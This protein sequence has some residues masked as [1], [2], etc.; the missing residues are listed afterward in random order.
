MV[1]RRG[2]G[3]WVAVEGFETMAGRMKKQQQVRDLGGVCWRGK[4]GSLGV[5]ASG[6]CG[7]RA[8]T[9]P[10]MGSQVINC[11][12]AVRPDRHAGEQQNE[13]KTARR[14]AAVR[15]CGLGGSD[16]GRVG[17]HSHAPGGSLRTPASWPPIKR[18]LQPSLAKFR[19]GQSRLHGRCGGWP[20]WIA[21]I[22]WGWGAGC[23]L[24]R[25]IRPWPSRCAGP[26]HPAGVI[27]REAPSSKLC[28]LELVERFVLRSAAA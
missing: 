12:T 26:F 1:V 27:R 19:S 15:A 22:D 8:S 28:L 14:A 9:R 6:L 25:S 7:W 21:R 16:L 5:T 10:G 20:A 3:S 4:T 24:H 13:A 2:R 17:L 18:V 11:S 23:A